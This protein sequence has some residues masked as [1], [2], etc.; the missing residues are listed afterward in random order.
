M[1]S[2]WTAVQPEN[3]EKHFIVTAVNRD[4]QEV[5][6]TCV[7]QAVMSKRDYLLPWQD[8]LDA[9]IWQQGWK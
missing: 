2:K 4:A 1:L 5:V 7:L 9:S 8:L 6:E 3:K